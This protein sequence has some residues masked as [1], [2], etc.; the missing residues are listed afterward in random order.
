MRYFDKS[1]GDNQN[2]LPIAGF[3]TLK[4]R[5]FLKLPEIEKG[6]GLKDLIVQLSGGI[7]LLKAQ[8]G[9]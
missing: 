1:W 7:E 2:K 9:F 8:M 3:T 4:A 5:C 6:N